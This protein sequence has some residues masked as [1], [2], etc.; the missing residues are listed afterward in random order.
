MS[1]NNYIPKEWEP[2]TL[3]DGTEAR[4]YLS[5]NS[6]RDANGW[7]VRGT[8]IPGGFEITQDNAREMLAQRRTRAREALEAGA[9]AFLEKNGIQGATNTDVIKVIGEGLIARVKDPK[10][11]KGVEAARLYMAETEQSITTAQ[12]VKDAGDGVQRDALREL[13]KM[14]RVEIH[15]REAKITVTREE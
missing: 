4:R 2:I 12:D 10:N 11:P 6:I 5:D 8:K 9:A 1:N 14:G 15:L 13:A 7:P 3:E